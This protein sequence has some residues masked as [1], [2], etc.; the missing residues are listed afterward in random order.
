MGIHRAQEEQV[1]SST[2]STIDDPS[3]ETVFDRT[4]PRTKRDTEPLVFDYAVITRTRTVTLDELP[5]LE[6]AQ[7][8]YRWPDQEVTGSLDEPTRR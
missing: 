8:T 3:P 7:V 2:M 6:P 4:D 1:R 5:R